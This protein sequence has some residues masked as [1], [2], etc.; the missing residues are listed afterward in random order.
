MP[1]VGNFVLDKGYDAAAAITKYRAV[2]FSADE[3]VTPV[4]AITDVIVGVEQFGV[5]AAEI[6]KGKGASVRRAPGITP[7]E[8]AGAIAVGQ[9]VTLEADG[10]CSALVGA[11]G[12]RIVGTCEHPVG[13]AGEIATVALA[14]A[15][16]LA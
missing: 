15:G 4:T 5:S 3:T 14:Q 12:K 1:P 9:Q 2:K 16:G 6:T 10:R 11:S 8:A 13:A 7:W